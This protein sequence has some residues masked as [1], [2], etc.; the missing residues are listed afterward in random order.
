[1]SPYKKIDLNNWNRKKH[2]NFFTESFLF[3]HTG[4]TARLD[5]TNLSKFCEE[6][7]LSFFHSCVFFIARELNRVEEFRQRIRPEGPI[8]WEK[9]NP[10]YTILGEDKQFLFCDVNFT[11]DLETFHKASKEAARCAKKSEFQ[12]DSHL[13]DNRL[14]MSCLP[15]IDFTHIS[16]PLHAAKEDSVPRVSWGK[17]SNAGSRLEMALNIQAHH[18]FV[19]GLH[20]GQVFD[21][22]QNSLDAI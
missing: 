14:F 5:V 13:E 22:L 1:M 18:A 20:F 8:V 15:W 21:G 9:I 2:Y 4:I 16:H 3:P 17:V 12:D 11:E 19:D 7:G 6:K 10:S